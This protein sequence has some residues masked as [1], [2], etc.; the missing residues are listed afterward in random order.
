MQRVI[1]VLLLGMLMFAT[2]ACDDDGSNTVSPTPGPGTPSPDAQAT[3][4]VGGAEFGEVVLASA[5]NPDTKEPI[6]EVT[7]FPTSAP[8]MHATVSAKN[9]PAGSQFIFRWTKGTAVAG[10]ITVNVEED[11]T[12]S[13]VAGS[14]RPPGAIPVGDDWLVAV[15]YNGTPLGSVP[16]SVR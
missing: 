8:E 9:V 12:D 3:T 13:W 11:I 2:V 1:A 5:I 6:T 16:F 4:S 15:S 7:F 10:T 14:I